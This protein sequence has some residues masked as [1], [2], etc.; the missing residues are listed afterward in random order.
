MDGSKLKLDV[1]V[2]DGPGQTTRR[3]SVEIETESLPATTKLREHLDK[4]RQKMDA[5]GDVI[6]EFGSSVQKRKEIVN[7]ESLFSK[8]N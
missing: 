4:L 2:D 5:A 7:V 6:S 8:M 1:Y 3:I